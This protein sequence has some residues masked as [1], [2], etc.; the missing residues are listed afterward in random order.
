MA[1]N[2]LS[3]KWKTA[4]PVAVIFIV[5]SMLSVILMGSMTRRV[6]VEEV[7]D[8]SVK[9][10][11]ET[12]LRALSALM[13]EEDY[14]SSKQE[15]LKHMRH[16]AEI[17]IIRAKAMDAQYGTVASSSY[18][19]DPDE[20]RV[21]DSGD[22]KVIVDNGQIRGIYPYTASRNSMGT[23]CLDCHEVREGTVLGAVSIT[24]HS[25]ETFARLRKMQYAFAAI[26]FFVLIFC[27]LIVVVVFNVTHSPLKDL[28]SRVRRMAVESLKRESEARGDEVSVLAT[29]MDEMVKGFGQTLRKIIAATGNV[30]SAIDQLRNMSQIT[31]EG[32]QTQTRQTARIA[33][34]A[35][36]M[37]ATIMDIS[38]N[39]SDASR[40][41][42]EAREM[43][44]DGREIAEGSVRKMNSFY[45]SVV[46]LAGTIE[47]LNKRVSEIGDVVHVIKD[48]ADQTN[49]LALN[50]AIE[51]ARAG[52]QGRGFAVVADE[53]RKLAE[54]TIK[55]TDEVTEKIGS[56][57]AE[58]KETSSSMDSASMEL[59]ETTK[60]IRS[61]GESLKSI[62]EKVELVNDQ[63]S[64]IAAAVEEQSAA[65]EEVADNVES[66][67]DIAEEIERMS[68][69]VM[70]EV[71]NVSSVI[72]E[73]REAEMEFAIERR[74]ILAIDMAETD[75]RLWVERVR[76]H[77]D[78]EISI[79]P[80]KIA[81]HH[82][83]RLG[84]WFY[85]EGQE[86][87]SEMLEFCGLEGVHERLH[88]L[89]KDAVLYHDAG[90]REEARKS[91]AEMERS[92]EEI[93]DILKSIRG[94]LREAES[95]GQG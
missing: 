26:S 94:N 50:A 21:V 52:E 84:I 5:F 9:G 33:H 81:D 32:A 56:V 62:V 48:I 10:Y 1:I 73:L 42:Q 16:Y 23:N 69:D 19:S 28:T 77:I 13:S 25:T 90:E 30:S 57:Q 76:A 58:S 87:C 61:A 89:G 45:N 40:V 2:D 67:S 92:S 20:R 82:S 64:R 36:Q 38:S 70:H 93:V 43:A 59:T 8:S 86:L 37:K 54:R 53:V 68:G 66:T 44:V 95:G 34:V 12:V 6:V 75:H 63:V 24:L 46:K 35:E 18:P 15:F 65:S 60:Y 55:A 88:E 22:R 51:A 71:N 91:F 7:L 79:D 78:G 72:D 17:R 74:E 80:S 31:T 83:C 29:L 4:V 27:I 49:L 3:I 14:S 39:A 41:S 47:Q 11:S 85:G